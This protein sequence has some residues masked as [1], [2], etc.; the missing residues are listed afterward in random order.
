M[1]YFSPALRA[2]YGLFRF[3]ED[4]RF[5]GCYYRRS[6]SR[7]FLLCVFFFICAQCTPVFKCNLCISKKYGTFGTLN[8]FIAALYLKNLFAFRTDIHEIIAH[9]RILIYGL[10]KWK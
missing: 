2:G 6:R 8:S 3:F 7:S 5:C 1:F 4:L 9:I 10:L